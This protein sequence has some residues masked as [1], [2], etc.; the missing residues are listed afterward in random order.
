MGQSLTRAAQWTSVSDGGHGK[1]EFNQA[2]EALLNSFIK[3]VDGFPS[4]HPQE[5]QYVFKSPF[6]WQTSIPPSSFSG[7]YEVRYVRTLDYS[8]QSKAYMES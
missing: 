1:L 7:D 2:N 5:S 4:R 3:F 6:E 8:N